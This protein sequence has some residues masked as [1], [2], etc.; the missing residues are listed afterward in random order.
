MLTK[1]W[2]NSGGTAPVYKN[3]ESAGAEQTQ[4]EV[5]VNVFIFTLSFLCRSFQVHFLFTA[6]EAFPK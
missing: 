2:S 5:Y 4:L 3:V 1:A 6:S